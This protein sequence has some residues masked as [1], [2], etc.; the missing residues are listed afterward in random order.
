MRPSFLPSLLALAACSATPPRDEWLDSGAFAS[1]IPLV[2]VESSGWLARDP[3]AGDAARGI[4][5]RVTAWPVAACLDVTEDGSCDFTSEPFALCD[6]VGD[7]LRC[8]PRPQKVTISRTQVFDGT[9]LDGAVGLSERHDEASVHAALSSFEPM[10]AVTDGA[11][12][13]WLPRQLCSTRADRVSSLPPLKLC[14]VEEL[15]V[16]ELEIDVSGERQRIKEQLPAALSIGVSTQQD[17]SGLL[18]SVSTNLATTQV[19]AQVRDGATDEVLW[20]ST[21]DAAVLTRPSQAMSISVPGSAVAELQRGDRVLLLQ[22]VAMAQRTVGDRLLVQRV[23]EA[24]V[25]IQ[26]DGAPRE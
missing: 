2:V 26:P 21:I 10:G 17:A 25:W 12:L 3:R 22:V 11:A 4:L 16:A 6:V 19:L 15:G 7:R 24:R 23:S 8:L 14:G 18:L 5:P 1:S 9:L 20:D 13:C